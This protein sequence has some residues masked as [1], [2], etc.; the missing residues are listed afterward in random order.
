MGFQDNFRNA[1][2]DDG[3]CTAPFDQLDLGCE[4][5]GCADEL[6]NL[7]GAL[8]REH[9]ETGRRAEPPTREM[10]DAFN[11]LVLAVAKVKAVMA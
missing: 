8:S 5:G 9:I 1:I 7:A 3:P 10:F 4:I 11:A 2:P 6:S